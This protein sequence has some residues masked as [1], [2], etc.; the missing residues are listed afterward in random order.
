MDAVVARDDD[1]QSKAALTDAFVARQECRQARD[2]ARFT[3]GIGSG[4]TLLSN[5]TP[6]PGHL[7]WPTFMRRGRLPDNLIQYWLMCG[8]Y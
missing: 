2:E 6:D 5:D 8:M 1:Q 4:V 3:A 7:H